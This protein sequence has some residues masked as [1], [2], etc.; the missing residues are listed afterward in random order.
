MSFVIAETLW[1]AAM[2]NDKS[3]SQPRRVAA[4]KL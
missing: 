2:T 4:I 3:I 1:Q